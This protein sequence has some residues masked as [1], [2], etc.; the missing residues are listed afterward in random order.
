MLYL[1]CRVPKW[2]DG[3]R[4]DVFLR[5]QGLSAGLIRAVKHDAGGFFVKDS[6]IHTNMPV[7]EGQS[8]WFALPPEPST[9]VTPQ[10]MNLSIRWE[11]DFAIVLDKPAGLAVHPTL[12][13]PD[14]TLANGWLWHLT[15][16]GQA[17]VFR[18]VNRI[19]KNTSGL[20][21]CAG[22]AFAAPLLAQS[23][24]KC[25]LAIAEGSLPAEE[26]RI[27]APHR[28]AGGFHHR[29][30]GGARRQTQR[31]PLP[32]SGPGRRVFAGGLPA[33]HRP[34][35]SDPGPFFPFGLPPGGGYPLRRPCGP[36]CPACAALCGA[37]LPPSPGRTPLPA[38]QPAAGGYGRAV[39][40]L[41]HRS[42][43]AGPVC[44][45]GRADA[46]AALPGRLCAVHRTGTAAFPM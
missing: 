6:P 10:P 46:P 33:A 36:D 13:Y 45:A 16:R 27:D 4:L 12:N 19:D 8:V 38:A 29:A 9:T 20:V 44:L 18:P 3:Q 28:P 26:G 24:R 34:H 42:G 1:T 2:A 43:T 17:G 31:H 7:T 32:G 37:E 22:N 11:D 41:R 23:A 40:R 39:R 15:T 5:R 14:A 21:L 30:H 25:Y 35:P